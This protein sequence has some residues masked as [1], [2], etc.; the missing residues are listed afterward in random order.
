MQNVGI[1][2]LGLLV[3]TTEVKYNLKFE[4]KIHK[5]FRNVARC[6]GL[7]VCVR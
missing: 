5:N 3:I 4:N 1:L 6:I 2:E 7:E